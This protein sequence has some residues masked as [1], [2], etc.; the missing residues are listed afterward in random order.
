[1]DS[2]TRTTAVQQAIPYTARPALVADKK[3]GAVDR[4]GSPPRIVVCARPETTK[5]YCP[6][7]RDGMSGYDDAFRNGCAAME[8]GKSD[9]AAGLFERALEARPGDADALYRKGRLLAE[10]NRDAEA[11]ECFD[12]MPDGDG[13]ALHGKGAMLASMGHHRKAISYYERA[14]EIDPGDAYAR[15]GK[16]ASLADLKKYG[17][18]WC[19]RGDLYEMIGTVPDPSLLFHGLRPFTG[20]DSWDAME[21]CEET[22]ES[23]PDDITALYDKAC[24]LAGDGSPKGGFA[25]PP[26]HGC[27]VWPADGRADG[28]A[29][30]DRV[31][32]LDPGNLRALQNRG[33]LLAMLDR[34]EEALAC[35]E[36]VLEGK[37]DDHRALFCKGYA[38]DRLGRGGEAVG[39]FDRAL[40][41]VPG[42]PDMLDKKGHALAWLGRYGEALGCFEML[43]AAHP[44]KWR[45]WHNKAT[46]LIEMDRIREAVECIDGEPG[47]E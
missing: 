34:E 8:A 13:R 41:A 31:L 7:W 46:I 12:G 3:I 11:L 17:W 6:G 21:R 22:L 40:E 24:L 32:E 16:D 42:H 29:C 39:Y 27:I 30:F 43:R 14:L 10:Q 36:R 5:S 23:N 19:K 47:I 35:F 20:S 38:L 26:E 28:L 1:M 37:P 9:E 33:S 2:P 15:D 45:H 44:G 4:S 25:P 18:E